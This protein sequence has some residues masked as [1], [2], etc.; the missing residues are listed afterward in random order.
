MET[1]LSRMEKAG[2]S[3]QTRNYFKAYGMLLDALELVRTE[4][5]AMYGEN[6]LQG[7]LDALTNIINEARTQTAN[8]AIR[9]I[10]QRIIEDGVI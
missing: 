2:I 7:E 4:H 6:V 5:V 9:A 8:M 10:E 3:P 1:C